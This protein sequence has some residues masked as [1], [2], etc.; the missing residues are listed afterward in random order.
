MEQLLC[1]VQAIN[2]AF[3]DY[4]VFVEPVSQQKTLPC[5]FVKEIERKLEPELGDYY[6]LSRS[7]EV[8]YYDAEGKYENCMAVAAD[9]DLALQRLDGSRGRRESFSIKEGVLTVV[10]S[11]SGRC[12]LEQKQPAEKMAKMNIKMELTNWQ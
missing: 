2:Q 12:K 11:Y 8:C 9:L 10:Y 4:P 3:P 5:F 1:C 6:R 7:Y